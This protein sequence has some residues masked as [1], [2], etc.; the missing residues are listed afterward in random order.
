MAKSDVEAALPGPL[1]VSALVDN[2][3]GLHA[4]PSIKL[5]Q[6]A[7]RYIAIAELALDPAGPRTD[8]KNPVQVTR[9][10][11][12]RGTMLHVRASGRTRRR[13]PR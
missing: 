9:F 13:S 6:L 12:P 7:K 3:I 8:A 1:T 10:R 2:A 4:R 5:T 11:A